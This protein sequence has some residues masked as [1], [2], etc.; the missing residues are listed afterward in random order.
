M[1]AGFRSRLKIRGIVDEACPVRDVAELSHGQVIEAL[2]ANRLTSPA[3]LVLPSRLNVQVNG[4]NLIFERHA[5]R[6][7]AA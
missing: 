5:R 4:P 7:S 3:P 1:V 2:V 6:S